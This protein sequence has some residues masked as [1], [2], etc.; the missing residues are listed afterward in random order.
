MKISKIVVA[1]LFIVTVVFCGLAFAQQK[2]AAGAAPRQEYL[3][4]MDIQLKPGMSLEWENYLKKD[5][6]PAMKKSGMNQ[7]TTM[8]TNELGIDDYYT[9][10]WPMAGLAELDGPN[11]LE[12]ALGPD[13]LVVLLSNVQRCVAGSRNYILRILPNH[14]IAP[15]PGYVY[16]MAVVATAIVAPGRTEEFENNAKAMLG[17]FAKTNAKAVHMTNVGLGGNPNEYRTLVAFDSFT[18]LQNFLPAYWKAMS[19]A[20]L[21]PAT[22]IVLHMNMQAWEDVPELSIE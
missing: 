18:D 21:S 9:M 10:F 19:E 5:L 3:G 12:K 15:K 16:K 22:G 7:I 20:K 11:P 8:K 1:S 2:P 4:V 17:V 14:G 6:L 13:G